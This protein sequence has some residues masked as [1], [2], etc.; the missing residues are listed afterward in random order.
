MATTTEARPRH[1]ISGQRFVLF[2][3]DWEGYQAL[4][5]IVGDRRVRV[6]YDR[7]NVE[8]M[9]PLPSHERYKML[10]GRMIDVITEEMDIP[11]MSLGSTTFNR[12]DVDRGLEPDQC[13]YFA[14]LEGVRDWKSVKLDV[15]PP[16]DL[17]I[18][19]EIASSSL[20]RL[21]IYSALK[22]PE[23]WKFD[24]D[25]LTPFLR[26]ADGTYAP[27]EASRALSFVPL[28]EIARFL[29][30]YDMNNKTPW[31]KAFRAW[32]RV[33]LAPGVRGGGPG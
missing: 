16:P 31:I 14:S 30:E 4:L 25:E 20:D 32:V 21:G 28:H 3:V 19:I 33:V 1:Q 15:D 26:Q 29:R 24:G 12:E 6:T 23:V 9:T 18:E 17:A 2:N 7:G 8:L 27:T 5:K 22:I 13:Y 10:I 11:T